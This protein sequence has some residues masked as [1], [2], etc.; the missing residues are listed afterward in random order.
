MS[1]TKGSLSYFEILDVLKQQGS[2]DFGLSIKLFL[3]KRDLK[4]ALDAK[5]FGFSYSVDESDFGSDDSGIVYDKTS[6]HPLIEML[7]PHE[8]FRRQ[9][10]FQTQEELVHFLDEYSKTHY[11]SSLYTTQK[12]EGFSSE[13]KED[14]KTQFEALSSEEKSSLVAY[15]SR[16]F[17]V[18]NFL[19]NKY[20]NT[21]NIN[22]EE[23]QE[24]LHT[25][26]HANKHPYFLSKEEKLEIQVQ[27]QFQSMV[28]EQLAFFRKAQENPENA[29]FFGAIPFVDFS[30]EEGFI[31]GI[32]KAM[33]VM[34][35][36][37]SIKAPSS[38]Q[39]YRGIYGTSKLDRVSTSTFAS[40]TPE[41]SIAADFARQYSGGFYSHGSKSLICLQVQEGTPIIPL[42]FS[43]K[44][45]IDGVDMESAMLG[46]DYE[47]L[48]SD[49]IKIKVDD[50]SEDIQSEILINTSKCM[51]PPLS[52]L[53]EEDIVTEQ[54]YT[55][56]YSSNLGVETDRISDRFAVTKSIEDT[57]ACQTS[58]GRFNPTIAL[59]PSYSYSVYTNVPVQPLVQTDDNLLIE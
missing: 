16:M 37:S 3:G 38:F 50:Q 4:E 46:I 30:S 31:G 28:K 14:L 22:L 26:L 39:L 6:I 45:T 18:M 49:A 40:C 33:S 1:E 29:E 53:P 55:E 17:N 51:I 9:R 35:G 44:T 41:V 21:S 7:N 20:Q 15:K 11:S 57:F 27:R 59:K 48:P 13:V 10:S 58:M 42:M 25:P 43:V 24:Y 5:S 19:W 23:V 32:V 36:I 56:S 12:E 34:E 8:G 52:E 47:K 2:S 54:S